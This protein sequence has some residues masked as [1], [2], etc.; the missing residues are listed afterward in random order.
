[1]KLFAPIVL[2]AAA[3]CAP[4]VHAQDSAAV[5]D[6]KQA[7][8]RW[9]GLLDQGNAVA[10]Y[11]QTGSAFQAMVPKASWTDA[12]ASARAGLGAVKSRSLSSAT[13]TRTIP[14]APAGEYVVIQYATVFETKPG[15]IETVVPMRD[16][17]GKWKVS[18]YFIK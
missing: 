6:A 13:F 15:A 10:T 5:A 4:L 14:N 17:D 7:A 2:L 12:M 9:L 16:R 3:L 1:M 8:E 18:G 11:E